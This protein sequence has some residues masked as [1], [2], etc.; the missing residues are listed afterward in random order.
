MDRKGVSVVS[1][2]KGWSDQQGCSKNSDISLLSVVD[3]MDYW[4]KAQGKNYPGQSILFIS[5]SVK[6]SPKE[7]APRKYWPPI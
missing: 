7:I 2:Y 3:N 5:P 6:K 4:S 1:L